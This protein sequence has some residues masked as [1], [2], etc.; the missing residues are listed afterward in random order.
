MRGRTFTAQRED[1]IRWTI[2]VFDID[3]DASKDQLAHLSLSIFYDPY[4]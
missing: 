3:Q 4:L 1:N 2:Y